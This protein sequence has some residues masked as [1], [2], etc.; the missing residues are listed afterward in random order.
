[1]VLTQCL[2]NALGKGMFVSDSDLVLMARIIERE[3]SGLPATGDQSSSVSQAKAQVENLALTLE[4]A[5]QDGSAMA[6]LNL[7]EERQA[8]RFSSM[9]V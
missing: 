2:K 6:A 8:N 9:A 4:E 7:A 1:M 5:L 3:V